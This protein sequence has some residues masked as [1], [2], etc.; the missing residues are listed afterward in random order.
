MPTPRGKG[1]GEREGRPFAGAALEIESVEI[2]G[3][4]VEGV[5]V[6]PAWILQTLPDG[7][8][9]QRVA[10]RIRATSRLRRSSSSSRTFFS[11][12]RFGAS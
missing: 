5:E 3:V 4:E 10:F 6:E 11:G 9:A 2:E 12:G 1:K 8:S 7:G